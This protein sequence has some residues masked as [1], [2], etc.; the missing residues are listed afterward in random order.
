MALPGGA[1]GCLKQ[2]TDR[3]EIAFT[4]TEAGVVGGIPGPGA[5]FGSAVHPQEMIHSAEI[6]ERIYRQV[7]KWKGS[8]GGG[9]RCH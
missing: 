7:R 4:R 2:V 8:K 1:F 5:F 3:H 6:F 9:V